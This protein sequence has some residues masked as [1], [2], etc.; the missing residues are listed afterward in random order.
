MAHHIRSTGF[1]R[2]RWATV[3]LPVTAV[4]AATILAVFIW[5]PDSPPSLARADTQWSGWGFTHT[6]FSADTGDPEAVARAQSAVAQVPMV[7]AQAIMG[8]GVDNPE[9]SPGRFDFHSLDRRMDFIHRSGGDPVIVLCCAPDWMKGGDAGQ[10]D[11]DRLEDAPLPAHFTDFA[12]LSAAVAKRYPY[13]RHFLVWNEFKGFFDDAAGQWDA[14]GYTTLYNAVY[15]AVKAVDSTNRVGGPYLDFA[16]QPMGLPG[17]ST[18]LQG[19][20]GA[21]DQQT[22]DAFEFWNLHKKGADFVA[23]DAHATTAQGAPDEFTAV[24]KFAAVTR[25]LRTQ[26]NLPVWWPE[27]YVEPTRPGWS[28]EHQ[29]ALRVAAMIE[30]ADGGTDTALYWNPRPSGAGCASCLWTDTWSAD[31]G[32][33]LPFLDVLQQFA[34]SFPPTVER[35]QEYVTDGLLALVSDRVRVIVNTTDRPISA[36]VDGRQVVWSAYQT[37]WMSTVGAWST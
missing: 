6:Q 2:R 13:V 11:W 30:L 33:P 28:A 14:A 5:I 24:Q 20:W 10:T 7:Q 8:W 26:V 21:V 35:H 4:V 23:V 22:I 36:S 32:Q 34:R 27:W 16:S 9:P 1:D 3:C 29:T 25:W 31:G 37:R 12:E 19:P 18:Q 15:D 17:S